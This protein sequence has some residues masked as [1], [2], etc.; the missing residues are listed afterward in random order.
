MSNFGCIVLAIM[1]ESQNQGFNTKVGVANVVLDRGKTP[2]QVVR[3]HRQ[4]EWYPLKHRL[5]PFKA[6]NPMEKAALLVARRAAMFALKGGRARGMRG[7]KF[8]FFNTK[9]LGKRFKTTNRLVV[10]EGLV[11]Y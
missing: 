5:T 1:M 9:K 8:K 3:A 6:K 10:S 7:K 2:C 4:F 11:F